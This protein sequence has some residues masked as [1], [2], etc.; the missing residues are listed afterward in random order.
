[1]RK[2]KYPDEGLFEQNFIKIFQVELGRMQTRWTSLRAFY[3]E[4]SPYPTN[5]MDFFTANFLQLSVWYNNFMNIPLARRNEINRKLEHNLFDYDHWSSAIAEYFKEPANGFNLVSCVYCDMAYVNAYEVDPDSE[6][7]YILNNAPDDELMKKLCTK[8]SNSL[9]VVKHARPFKTR[10]DFDRI[11]ALL[12]WAPNKYDKVFKP[13]YRFK[14]HF[15]LDHVLPKSRCRLVSLSLYNFV[16]SCQVCNQRLKKAKVL[17]I[18]GVA[19]EKLS[20]TSPNFDF[21]S[22]VHFHIIPQKGVKAGGLRPS[23]RPYD[24]ELQ[25]TPLDSDYNVLVKV[26]KLQ[27]RYAHHKIKALHWLEMKCKYTDARISMMANALHHPSFSFKRI[28]SDIFQDELYKEG[29]MCFSKLRGD[30]L[31]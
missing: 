6:A 9:N 27:E 12:R 25:L 22:Q 16:P 28:K 5:V 19:N 3:P 1:M 26:F 20:P 7:I 10:A 8:S 18:M 21:E 17:G 31:K 13:N 23:I 30:M 29:S 11:G 2:M 14:H 4:L 24:Y 15:D